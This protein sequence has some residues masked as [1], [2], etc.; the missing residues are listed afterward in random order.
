MDTLDEDY[1][2]LE[3]SIRLG[4]VSRAGAIAKKLAEKKA[5]ISIKISDLPFDVPEIPL[6]YAIL[7][8]N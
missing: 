2:E 7:T 4:H 1:C 8:A 3:T 6:K 5:P